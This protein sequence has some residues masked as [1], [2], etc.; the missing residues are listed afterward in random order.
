VIIT[1]KTTISSQS[2]DRAFVLASSRVAAVVTAIGRIGSLP[3]EDFSRS[4][5]RFAAMAA[6]VAY[7]RP[8]GLTDPLKNR[9]IGVIERDRVMSAHLFRPNWL[10]AP[11]AVAR[12]R[13]FNSALTSRMP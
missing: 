1:A 2:K 11:N 7:S 10:I 4:K 8:L 3:D 9:T 12:R 5:R 6:V 13:L